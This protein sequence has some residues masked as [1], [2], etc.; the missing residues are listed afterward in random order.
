MK[1]WKSRSATYKTHFLSAFCRSM[2]TNSCW[3]FATSLFVKTV[4]SKGYPQLFFFASLAALSYY[5]YFAFRGH[6]NSE[7]YNVYRGVLI[8]AFAASLACCLEPFS[9]QLRAYDQLLLYVFV[10]SV[11]TVDLIG[12]TLGPIVLQ[13]SVN[14]V[15]FR[16]VYQKIV[17]MELIARIT[18]SGLV[19]LFS[20]THQL[21]LVYPLAWILL[22]SHF[23]L[24]GVSVWRMRVLQTEPQIEATVSRPIDAIVSNAI[25]SKPANEQQSGF[26]T[27]ALTN[28]AWS[29]RFIFTNPLVRVAM[30]IMVWSTVT[31]FVLENLFY[32][33]TD[34][35]FSS[36]TQLA[37]FI[38]ALTIVIYALS[39]GLH[40]LITRVLNAR[41]QLASLLSIQPLNILVFAGLAMLLPP[42]WPLVLLMVT[43]NIVHRSIQVPMS[44]QCLVPVPKDSKGTI[45]SLI[46]ILIALSTMA[47]SGATALLKNT[48]HFEDYIVF[49]LVLGV[50]ILFMVTSLDS[51]Y[52]RNLWSL[53]QELRSGRWQ[54]EQNQFEGLSM[55]VL[56]EEQNVRQTN[57]DLVDIAKQP[58]LNTYAF[59]HDKSRLREATREHSRLLA[60]GKTDEQIAGLQICFATGFPWHR[61]PLS[62]ALSSSDSEVREY[63]HRASRVNSAFSDLEKFTAVFRR[64][65]K[66]LAMHFVQSEDEQSL[67]ALFRLCKAN[68]KAEV[69]TLITGF[70]KP[71]FEKFKSLLIECISDGEAVVSVLPVINRMY[72]ERFKSSAEYRELLQTLHF[73]KSVE[74]INAV[75]KSKLELLSREKIS[76]V[77][78]SKESLNADDNLDTFM[79]TLYLDEYRL[80][81]GQPDETLV[82]SISEFS[83][84]SQDETGILIDMHLSFLKRSEFFANWVSI[85]SIFETTASR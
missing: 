27:L 36:A 10:V 65:I 37:S 53:F 51:Y 77:P 48:L 82:D 38:S 6:K 13:S 69:E 46:S 44:R 25:V 66:T 68:D 71:R 17:A 7:P 18:A 11:M 32:Q 31:K 15:I 20:Q 41:L 83:N 58:V 29:I 61:E 67:E 79:H 63:A 28:V 49:L 56:D 16:Q 5:V 43:Y 78:T 80:S 3:I 26:R 4:G 84:L 60:S 52:I 57:F 85:L 9:A 64:R 30:S 45:V 22:V 8:V 73:N 72:A 74:A 14:P 34:K 47:T 76:L 81:G 35:T 1:L 50:A 70:S 12:T 62:E 24:F 39:L 59:S 40:P 21:T 42:F 2:F 55:V 19:W 23:V 54:D 33:V 75:I